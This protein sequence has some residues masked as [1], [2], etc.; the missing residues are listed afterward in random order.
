MGNPG[1]APGALAERCVV[2]A[3]CC[4]AIPASMSLDEAMLVEPLSIGLHA[5][6][7]AQLAAGMKIA[8]LGAG[9][10]GLS[11]LLCAKATAPCAALVTDLLEERLAVARRCGADAVWNAR[12]GDVAAR[13]ARAE[14]LGLD[15]VFECSGDPACL[16]QGQS[17][18]APG[19]ALMLVGIP[20]VDVVTF[21]PHRMRRLELRF[22]AVRRQ[23]DCVAPAVGLIAE[24]RLDPSPLLTHRFPLGD[25]SAAFELVAGYRDGVIKAVVDVSGESGVR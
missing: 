6:R 12:Q 13:I 10:I 19:G 20:P 8:V 17:L 2:P 3:A 21:D 11:V 18:L 1:E 14:P 16:Q 5:V 25:V 9:P 15:L 4:V 24:R 7:L 22:Q 23:N